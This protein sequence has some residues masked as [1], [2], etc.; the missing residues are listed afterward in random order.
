MIGR[1]L[2][3]ADTRREKVGATAYEINRHDHIG[4]GDLS[5]ATNQGARGISMK[6]ISGWHCR[7]VSAALTC[8]LPC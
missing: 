3:T 1:Q 8:G 5:R 6:T 7:S 2:A 4:D